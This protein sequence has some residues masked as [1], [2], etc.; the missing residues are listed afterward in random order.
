MT[1]LVKGKYPLFSFSI[2]ATIFLN[3]EDV[4]LFRYLNDIDLNLKAALVYRAALLVSME[5]Y[6]VEE[7]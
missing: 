4:L 1:T 7:H 2:W 3:F 5:L 6:H